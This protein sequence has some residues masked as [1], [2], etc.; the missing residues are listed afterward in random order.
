MAS[1]PPTK[2]ALFLVMEMIGHDSEQMSEHYTHVGSEAL[3]KAAEALP[4]LYEVQQVN[5]A[6]IWTKQS[7]GG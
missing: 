4:D 2:P 3:K 1:V 7:H 5:Y 6:Q